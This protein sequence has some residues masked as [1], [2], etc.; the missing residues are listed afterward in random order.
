MMITFC[1]FGLITM[2]GVSSSWQL[3]KAWPVFV[4]D[5]SVVT[6]TTLSNR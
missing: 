2:D 3:L 4:D 6:K 5:P 1:E